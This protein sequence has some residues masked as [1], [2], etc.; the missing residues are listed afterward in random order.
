MTPP[1]VRVET[2]LLGPVETPVDAYWGAH[3]Q[4]ATQNFDLIGYP[5]PW[6]LIQA[7]AQVKKL[8]R[9]QMPNWAFGYIAR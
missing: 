8:A 5:A 9:R 6:P 4:R 1:A 2:D 7:M 3:T